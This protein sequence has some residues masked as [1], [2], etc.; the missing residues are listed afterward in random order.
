VA[1]ERRATR[2]HRWW[3]FLLLIVAGASR[4]LLVAA[5]PDAGSTLG[6]EALGCVWAALVAWSLPGRVAAGETSHGS[7][8]KM[9]LAGAMLIGGPMT[10]IIVRGRHLDGGGMTMALA[11]TPVV[12]AIASAAMSEGS[13]EGLSG[14]MWPGL[15]AV[16]GLLL[17]LESPELGDVRSD[18]ALVL[19]P[20]LTGVGAVMFCNGAATR[21]RSWALALVGAS[22]LFALAA[23]EARVVEHLTLSMTLPAVAC[24]GLLALLGVVALARLEAVRWS[25]Q[26]T[27]LP[28]LTILEGI[29]LVRPTL[30]TR[31]GVGL[32]LL[33]LASV[34]LL[35]P[36]EPDEEVMG[37]VLPR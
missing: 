5:R 18:V 29:V 36:P 35:L 14:K 24:D 33:T 34:F 12:I 1:D 16:A 6:S 26:F 2:W 30:S 4:W 27:L 32:A 25:A 37:Q 17:V 3:P 10:A 22:A 8:W 9:V 23:T 11:L 15:A 19:S 7:A 20:V 13:S 21:R 28:L 31:W